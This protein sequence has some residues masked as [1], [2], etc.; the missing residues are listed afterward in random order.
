VKRRRSPR[1]RQTI[2]TADGATLRA[3]VLF[4]ALRDPAALAITPGGRAFVATS[5][6]VLIVADGAVAGPP[7]L[8]DGPV[9]ALD[10]SPDFAR[11]GLVFVTQAVKAA[12]GAQ[13]FRTSRLRD[14]GGWF[15]DRMVILEHGPA[16]SEPSAALRFGPDGK[17]HL[18][19]DNGGSAAAAERMSDWRGKLLRMEADGRT[20]PDQAAASPVLWQGLT[21]PRGFAWGHDG[22]SIWLAD[23]R[24]RLERLRLIVPTSLAPRRSAQ[25]ASY[26]LPAGIGVSSVAYYGGTV[27]QQ[28]HGD[29]F[30]AGRDG[31][32][33]LRIR[34]DDRERHRPVTTEKLLEGHAVRALVV[35]PDGAIY[36]CTDTQLVRF[37]VQR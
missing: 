21:A 26:A 17:L 33:L 3:E 10:L 27:I 20:P 14:M 5:E 24:D 29:L 28:F 19:F 4:D 6:G 36:I 1:A 32:Y 23:A 34:F 13:M 2:S 31:R 25:A 16:S 30:I 35:G 22:V 37:S 15:A 8:T 18:A 12:G 9:L 11:D 7:Q